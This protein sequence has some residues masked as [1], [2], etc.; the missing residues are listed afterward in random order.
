MEDSREKAYRF[1]AY[2][3]I[4][5]AVMAI[6]TSTI[7]IPMAYNYVQTVGEKIRSEMAF[8][9]VLLVLSKV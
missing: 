9:Q 1:V 8:C 2:S 7:T 4:G 5:F 3:A 6:L